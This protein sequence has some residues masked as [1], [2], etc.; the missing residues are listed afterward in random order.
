LG[1]LRGAVTVV[2]ADR[3]IKSDN[4]PIDMT[5]VVNQVQLSGVDSSNVASATS[6][7]V[8]I[9]GN[10]YTFIMTPTNQLPTTPPAVS[11]LTRTTW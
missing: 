1:G 5:T 9:S 10:P 6:L 3:S 4:S 8:T 2:Y 11:E 7:I